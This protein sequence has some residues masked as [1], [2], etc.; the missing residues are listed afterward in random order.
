[1]PKISASGV[2]S[3][4]GADREVG[5]VT[6]AVGEQ[7]DLVNPTDDPD[8]DRGEGPLDGPD[9]ETEP[10]ED[11]QPVDEPSKDDDSWDPARKPGNQTPSF[12]AKKPAKSTAPKKK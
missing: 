5:V 10:D 12:D 2:P 4:E 6:N 1:M 8:P 9:E 7:F 3:F 11:G